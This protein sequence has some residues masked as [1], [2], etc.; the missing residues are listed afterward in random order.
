MVLIHLHLTHQNTYFFL[1]EFVAIREACSVVIKAWGRGWES[2]MESTCEKMGFLSSGSKMTN[3]SHI[4]LPR[5]EKWTKGEKYGKL[6]REAPSCKQCRAGRMRAWTHTFR[7]AGREMGSLTQP[8]HLQL[9]AKPFMWPQSP[10]LL[11]GSKPH[12]RRWL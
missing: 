5:P 4:F 10:W 6:G 2:A 12:T 3:F 1:G 9:H 11:N 8:P 7:L